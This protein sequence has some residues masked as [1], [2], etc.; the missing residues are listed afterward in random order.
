MQKFNK[1]LVALDN[2]DIDEDLINAAAFASEI[3]KSKSVHFIHIIRDINI[4]DKVRKEFPNLLDDALNE[5]R[6]SIEQKIDQYFDNENVKTSIE[7]T[8]GIATKAILRFSVKNDIDLILMGRKNE[9]KG[10]GIVV[11]RVARRAACSLLI[12]PRN[13]DRE[14]KK[15]LIPVDFSAPSLDAFNDTISLV[16]DIEEIKIIA[17]NVYQ[18]PSGYHSTGKSYSEFA[19]IMAENVK[20]D[21]ENFAKKIDSQGMDISPIYTLDRHDDVISTVYKTAKTQKTD[22]VVISAKGRTRSTALFLGSRAEKMIQLDTEIPLF[23]IRPKGKL[24][25]ILDYLKKL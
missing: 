17:Q 8:S 22:L 5:R 3:G 7:I 1:L 4:P 20:S 12:V 2:S 25:G 14:I 18:V 24:E 23:V 16:K 11:Q 10:G 6:S 13:F 9:A 21:F 19:R 15:I